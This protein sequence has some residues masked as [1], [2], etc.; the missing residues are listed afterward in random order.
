MKYCNR[1][2]LWYLALVTLL[3]GILLGYLIYFFISND[4]LSLPAYFSSYS[5]HTQTIHEGNC[6][7]FSYDKL[8]KG[9]CIEHLPNSSN[10]TF[11]K[12]GTYYLHFQTVCSFSSN[13]NSQEIRIALKTNE[14]EFIRNYVTC[15]SHSTSPLSIQFLVQ[16]EANS[17]I[18]LYFQ[19]LSGVSIDC[20]NT[21][22]IIFKLD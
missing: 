17:P 6:L 18:T 13:T 5:P 9:S 11:L 12:E 2:Y 21:S 15:D 1:S 16:V 14:E 20:E 4:T 8:L 3:I 10:F 7:F 19:N 22:L